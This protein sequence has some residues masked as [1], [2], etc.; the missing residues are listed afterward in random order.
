MVGGVKMVSGVRMVSGIVKA[1]CV[2]SNSGYV[3]LS[4]G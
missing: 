1:C 4:R 2:K 3:R